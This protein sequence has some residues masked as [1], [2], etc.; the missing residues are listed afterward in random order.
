MFS[1]S[2]KALKLCYIDRREYYRHTQEHRNAC[3][4]EPSA[5]GKNIAHQKQKSK[6]KDTKKAA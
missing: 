4:E 6:E 3:N 2:A 1:Y 5:A